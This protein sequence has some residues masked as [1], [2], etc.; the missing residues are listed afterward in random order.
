MTNKPNTCPFCRSDAKKTALRESIEQMLAAVIRDGAHGYWRNVAKVR[1]ALD[2]EDHIASTLQNGNQ[3]TA[4]THYVAPTDARPP[5]CRFRL[6]D[7]GKPY[8]RSGCTACGKTIMTGLGR[9]C[10]VPAPKS[11]SPVDVDALSL[12]AADRIFH[13]M[14]IHNMRLAYGSN[15][16][17]PDALNEAQEAK[18]KAGWQ[19]VIRDA[20]LTAISPSPARG[21]ASDD[22]N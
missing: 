9:V 7:E 20:I 2:D 5:G 16:C 3:Q 18:E 10:D 19:I 17:L 11:I 12:Q 14:I 1:A 22:G 13:T 15:R 21:E 8:P 6:I 4:T